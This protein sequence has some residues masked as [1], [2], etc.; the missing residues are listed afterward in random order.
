MGEMS[1]EDP[2]AYYGRLREFVG[3]V[4]EDVA[5]L[6]RIAPVLLPEQ[7]RITDAFYDAILKEPETA[8]YVEGRVDALKKTHGKWFEE[9]F[10]GAYDRAY[11]E[12]RWRIGMAHVRIGLGPRWV[13][14][15]VAHIN[16]LVLAAL[17]EHLGTEGAEAHQS[18]ARLL[19]LDRAIIQLAYDEDRLDRFSE[20]TGMKRS[21]IEN[22]I[23]VAR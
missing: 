20:F 7:T 17:V 1:S 2:F 3:F 22:V 15:V 18:F 4:P 14:M 13:D 16:Q 23:K 5:T 9:L 19:E 8:A 6:K 12:R 11:F 10:D 21:L